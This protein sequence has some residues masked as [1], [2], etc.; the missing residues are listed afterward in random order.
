MFEEQNARSKIR[1]EMSDGVLVEVPIAV[2]VRAI[3]ERYMR[4]GSA[5][6]RR[7]GEAP[8]EVAWSFA[9]FFADEPGALVSLVVTSSLPEVVLAALAA[10]RAI[11]ARG[12]DTSEAE[13]KGRE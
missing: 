12:A 3:Q 7:P 9:D 2:V 10:A 4:A 8:G 13:K 6:G 1:L 5:E 11:S